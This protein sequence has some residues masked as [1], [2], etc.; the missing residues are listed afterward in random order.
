LDPTLTDKETIT[1]LMTI[2]PADLMDEYAV[3]TLVN[4]VQNNSV[5]LI[6]PLETPIVDSL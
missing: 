3:S 4:K 1:G 2:Y 5:D 6:R